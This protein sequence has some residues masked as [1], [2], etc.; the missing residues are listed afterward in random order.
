MIEK[1]DFFFFTHLEFKKQIKEKGCKWIV[2]LRLDA[3]DALAENYVPY[4]VNDIIPNVLAGTTPSL[5]ETWLGGVVASHHIPI[6]QY[7][8]GRCQYNNE[9]IPNSVPYS[10][11]SLGQA[12]ILHRDV[13]QVMKY[14]V[15]GGAHPNTVHLL[16]NQ[17]M[18]QFLRN[19][20]YSAKE[21]LDK[22]NNYDPAHDLRHQA[23]SRVKFIEATHSGF[24]RTS[25]VYFSSPLSGHFNWWGVAEMKV[26]TEKEKELM[27]SFY[28]YNMS[29]VFNP[30]NFKNLSIFD[31]CTSNMFFLKVQNKFKTKNCS[32]VQQIFDQRTKTATPPLI[33]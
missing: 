13:F 12:R 19:E 17:V 30:D 33:T 8:Y 24:G 28:G 18:H 3:D 32:E 31:A 7:G 1:N 15:R 4:L 26:C 9:A 5:G 2:L 22:A 29:Y 25:G 23:L 21:G 16:R 14:T 10:G 27:N 20:S 11:A 6:V